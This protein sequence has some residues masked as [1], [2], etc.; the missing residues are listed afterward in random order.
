M[1]QFEIFFSPGM[2][3]IDFSADP[4][5]AKTEVRLMNLRK[6]DTGRGTLLIPCPYAERTSRLAFDP[7]SGRAADKS[8]D[9][10]LFA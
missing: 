4:L 6:A 10:K 3:F 5:R 2:R 9:R 8:K 7:V 1:S